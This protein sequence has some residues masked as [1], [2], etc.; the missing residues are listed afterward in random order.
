MSLRVGKTQIYLAYSLAVVAK[1]PGDIYL[2]FDLPRSDRQCFKYTCFLAEA[3]DVTA[4][5]YR[6]Q[7]FVGVN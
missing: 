3:D 6:A 4:V 2:Q 7:N 5:T 1:Y